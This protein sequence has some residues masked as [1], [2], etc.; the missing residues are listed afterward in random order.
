MKTLVF[1]LETQKSIEEVGG[2]KNLD[3]LRLSL[4][5]LYCYETDTFTTYF[6]KDALALIEELESANKVIGF[7]LKKF[8]FPVLTGYKKNFQGRCFD[9]MLD[10][11]NT[12]GFF[13]NLNGLVNGTLGQEKSANG[14]L[15][16][17]WFKEGNFAE[18]EKYCIEDVRLTKEV[19]D[20]GKAN[21]KVY[22]R[23]KEG[24]K[25]VIPVD[26]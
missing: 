5:V 21:G 8:D 19:Y 18:I 25:R 7:N 17:E 24:R 14:L 23:D 22:F 1:D 3:K 11:S 13:V 20:F 26:W 9:L 4:G 16:L 15:A 12:I 6:E 10:I 2:Y